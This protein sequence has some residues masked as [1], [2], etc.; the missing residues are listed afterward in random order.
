MDFKSRLRNLRESRG[1]TQKEFCIEFNNYHMPDNTADDVNIYVQT[2]S[3]WENG[4]EPSYSVLKKLA[5]FFNVST[6]YLIG[7]SDIS[8]LNEFEYASN[9]KELSNKNIQKFLNNL[10]TVEKSQFFKSLSR[11]IYNL[12]LNTALLENR[13]LNKD[14]LCYINYLSD[15][16]TVIDEYTENIF[17]LFIDFNNNEPVL[18]KNLLID[19]FNS[20]STLHTEAASKIINILNNIQSLCLKIASNSDEI[21]LKD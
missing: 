6:D 11:Y 12:R 19:E 7:N 10:T 8:D 1:L 20:L 2:I 16:T 21:I 3:Y 13:S 15:F 14:D 9:M 17:K 4:R 18:K 5:N